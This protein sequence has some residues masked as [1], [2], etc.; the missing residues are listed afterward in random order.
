M[1]SEKNLKSDT[2]NVGVLTSTCARI[3]DSSHLNSISQQ[4]LITQKECVIIT[5]R[6]Q[7]SIRIYYM[8]EV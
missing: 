3:G 6:S 4:D 8:Y 5:I 7:F 1:R 2:V